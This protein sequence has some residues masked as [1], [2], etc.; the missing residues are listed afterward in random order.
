MS[1]RTALILTLIVTAFAL[2]GC[3]FSP[4]YGKY[5]NG[6]ASS[7]VSQ[8]LDSVYINTIPDR[9]G[10][11]LRNL[12]T[13]KFYKTGD[14]TRDNAAY[15]LTVSSVNEAIYGLGIAKDASATRS[16][17]KQT[18]SFT[19][20]RANDPEETPLLER[21]VTAVSSF[22]SLASQY[23]TLVTEEDARDQTI[24]DIA[25]QITVM[26]EGYFSNPSA[27]PVKKLEGPAV[28][29]ENDEKALHL[30]NKAGEDM[31]NPYREIGDYE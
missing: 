11:K 27:Y 10:Q 18:T 4:V 19:L 30:I 1:T 16:Q 25:N 29:G 23:T 7:P 15:R 21:T 8:A 13:D 14:K 2:V 26:L 31:H 22:N 9:S 12:L 28:S 24:K 5:A 20:T 6:G 17:I 3:G